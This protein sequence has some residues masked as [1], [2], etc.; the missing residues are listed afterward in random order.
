[1][2]L[3]VAIANFRPGPA[4]RFFFLFCCF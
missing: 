1:L 2:V 3:V 4:P